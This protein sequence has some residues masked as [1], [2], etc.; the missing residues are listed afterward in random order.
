MR[1]QIKRAARGLALM[2][3][4]PALLSFAIRRLI[5]GRDRALTSSSQALALV[6]GLLGSYLR[7]AFLSRVLAGC[8]PSATIEFGVLFSQAGARIDDNVYVGPRCHLGL[9][10]LE[11]NVLLGAG[12]HV[13][14][15]GATHGIADLDRPIRE[16][17]GVPATVRIG[18]GTW[19]GSNAVVLA[20]VGR[21]CVIAA[22]A[23]VTRPIADY[24]VAAGVPARAIKD[25]RRDHEAPSIA[26]FAGLGTRG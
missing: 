12:V 2:L 10:H 18:E 8:A 25:R 14:S 4:M 9:V 16:Q 20:D 3:V 15:G 22:G 23:V 5:V 26:R 11:R 17:P 24:V 6:P 19:V 7:R 1:E 21:H 13:P